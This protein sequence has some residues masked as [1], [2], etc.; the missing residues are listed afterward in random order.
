MAVSSTP[1]PPGFRAIAN[2]GNTSPA[3]VLANVMHQYD[4]RHSRTLLLPIREEMVA[5]A[6]VSSTLLSTLSGKVSFSPSSRVPRDGRVAD[7][8]W[9]AALNDALDDLVD[10]ATASPISPKKRLSIIFISSSSVVVSVAS[11][12]LILSYS[13]SPSLPF[14]LDLKLIQALE[15]SPASKLT[16]SG[17][18]YF[19]LRNF[20]FGN[21]S[22]TENMICS[23]DNVHRRPP[24]KF[25]NRKGNFRSR[26][27]KRPK[28]MSG[29]CV[30]GSLRTPPIAGPINI[31]NPT[32]LITSPMPRASRS[33]LPFA[34][35][36]TLTRAAIIVP[37]QMPVKNRMHTANGNEKEKPKVTTRMALLAVE[38]SNTN[39]RPYR[40]L[41]IPQ[42]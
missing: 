14:S 4:V 6:R 23:V 35:S 8:R 32:I 30:T 15:G 18:K 36:V 26:S 27:S 19:G 9:S 22:S 41:I 5:D 7:G 10:M 20:S 13:P 2:K 39:F 11:G 25:G 24:I 31:P 29:C 1:R 12:V 3:A 38:K 21:V 28:S 40:S 42:G 16:A 33:W 34:N 37:L 17:R